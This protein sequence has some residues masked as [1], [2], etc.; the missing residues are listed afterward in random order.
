MLRLNSST[1]LSTVPD[2]GS[3][4]PPLVTTQAFQRTTRQAE[5]EG[6]REITAEHLE[7]VLPK[8]LLDFT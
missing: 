4:V 5:G 7:K 6:A 3:R 1:T 8:L 2:N